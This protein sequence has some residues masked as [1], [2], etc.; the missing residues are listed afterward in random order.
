MALGVMALL[1]IYFG[2]R[3]SLYYPDTLKKV[4]NMNNA[5]QTKR[6]YSKEG[7]KRKEHH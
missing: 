1:P 6:T 3:L 4:K 5:E 2:A 7:S